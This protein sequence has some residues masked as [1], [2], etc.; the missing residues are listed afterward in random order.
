[1]HKCIVVLNNKINKVEGCLN[2]DE[3]Y[4]FEISAKI[5]DFKKI[6]LQFDGQ[7]FTIFNYN[8]ISH[9]HNILVLSHKI[10][11]F[12]SFLHDKNQ[13]AYLYNMFLKTFKISYML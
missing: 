6:I 5:D 4:Y 11:P 10:I 13:I 1:M 7:D 9:K 8:N 2:L 12:S 3:S